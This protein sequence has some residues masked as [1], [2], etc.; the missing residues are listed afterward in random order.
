MEAF[1]ADNSNPDVE[2]NPIKLSRLIGVRL[3]TAL[4]TILQQL[5]GDF[6]ARDD[7]LMVVPRARIES[8]VVLKQPVDVGFEKRTLSDALKELSDMT[9]V[10]VVLDAQKQTDPSMQITADFRNVPLES[11]VRVLADMAGMKSVVMENMIYVTSHESAERLKEELA[12]PP[13]PMTK[14]DPAAG[15]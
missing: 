8:G 9:G 1:K 5:N 14:A 12:K 13:R 7:V 15:M 2:N 11:A 3:R 6:Y 4:R 10:S